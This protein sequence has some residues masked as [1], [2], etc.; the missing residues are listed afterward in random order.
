M[1]AYDKK[2][3]N[4]IDQCNIEAITTHIRAGAN[5][6]TKDK[7]GKTALMIVSQ[8][9][10]KN[11]LEYFLGKRPDIH[12]IDKEGFSALFASARSGNF[13]N[14]ELLYRRKANINT[15]SKQ[16]ETIFMIACI[17]G[18]RDLIQFIFDKGIEINAVNSKGESALAYAVRGNNIEIINFL[19]NNNININM[20]DN[21]GNLPPLFLAAEHG[22]V[23]V[24]KLLLEKGINV[25]HRNNINL[26]ACHIAIKH[27]KPEFLQ[28][29]IKHGADIH[30]TFGIQKTTLLIFA[31]K[32]KKSKTVNYLLTQS[33][34]VNFRDAD[35]KSALCYAIELSCFEIVE[36]LFYITEYTNEELE[37]YLHIAVDNN[38]IDT[39]RL[40]IRV[41]KDINVTRLKTPIGGNT[42]ND[43]IECT[44][45]MIAAQKKNIK[46]VE[47]LLSSGATP[48]DAIFIA[49]LNN[50]IKIVELLLKQGA[51]PNLIDSNGDSLLYVASLKKIDKKIINIL[52]RYGAVSATSIK[53]N[54]LGHQ[55]VVPPA[56]TTINTDNCEIDNATILKLMYSASNGKID[57]VTKIVSQYNCVNVKDNNGATTLMHAS[58]Y[59]QNE[60]VTFLVNNG[61][62]INEVDKHNF[63]ALMH[64]SFTGNSDIATLLINCGAN[65]DIGTNCNTEISGVTALMFA[66]ILNHSTVVKILLD[67]GVNINMPDSKGTTALIYAAQ[68]KNSKIYNMLIDYGADDTVKNNKGHTA[69]TINRLNNFNLQEVSTHLTK[70]ILSALPKKNIVKTIRDSQKLNLNIGL[71]P[72]FIGN[73]TFIIE[74]AIKISRDFN[75]ENCTIDEVKHAVTNNTVNYINNGITLLMRAAAN[76]NMNALKLLIDNNADINA[77]NNN[78]SAITYATVNKHSKAIIFLLEKGAKPQLGSY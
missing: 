57:D 3:A 52:K 8:Y 66:S 6:E 37:S 56:K 48:N 75:I 70:N 49:V 30:A 15:L 24:L 51:D 78:V 22:H 67:A 42:I 28:E 68:I 72:E 21:D 20:I 13:E 77:I 17:E 60:I 40:I 19:I 58:Y 36:Q 7:K 2:L 61:A 46:I 4:S 73:S 11:E 31:S 71:D 74:R 9:G 53:A 1:S 32:K 69:A 55:V 26:N 10:N 23:D 14:F 29:L 18:R 44:A 33:V 47:L 12:A 54:T 5:I 43:V 76:G 65:L 34:D 64:A 16:N 62:N 35:N 38:D 45:L 41:I 59:G 50:E 25:N 27:D 39:V 63:T